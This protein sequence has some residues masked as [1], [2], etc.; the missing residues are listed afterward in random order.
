HRPDPTPLNNRAFPDA[1]A[2]YWAASFV[3]PPGSKVEMEG[4][5]PYSRFMSFI[6][7]DKAGLFVDGTARL[8]DRS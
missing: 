6:S 7:Y 2:I 1:G 8:H 4:L 5:Y 3:R